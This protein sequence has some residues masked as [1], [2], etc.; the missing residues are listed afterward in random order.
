MEDNQV[1]SVNKLDN[2]PNQNRYRKGLIPFLYLNHIINLH[3]EQKKMESYNK[4]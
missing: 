1:Y 4:Y 3:E 2:L